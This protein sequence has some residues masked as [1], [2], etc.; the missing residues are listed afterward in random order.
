MK[1]FLFS[2]A[3]LFMASLTGG[4]QSAADKAETEALRQQV[5]ELK[6][7]LADLQ[8][9]GASDPSVP[10]G[11]D[12]AQQDTQ[13]APSNDTQTE[14]S[15]D[16][17]QDASGDKIDELSAKV[18]AFIKKAEDTAANSGSGSLDAFFTL[19]QES[20]QI[21]RDIENYEDELER[22]YHLGALTRD[23]YK[24]KEL[25]LDRLDDSLDDA[26]D[27]LEYAFGIDD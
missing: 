15:N 21:E 9:D 17:Q 7:Q 20:H 19:N 2:A 1:K 16:T 8:Q 22:Q 11:S 23:G 5:N 25:A 18:D 27:R 26:K 12:A 14:L 13:S 24:T 10:A 4:C 6:E 3:A